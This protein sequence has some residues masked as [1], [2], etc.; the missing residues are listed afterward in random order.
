MFGAPAR[1]NHYLSAG[2]VVW[3]PRSGI[4]VTR[5]TVRMVT[6]RA[7][8]R[9]GSFWVRGPADHPRARPVH[10]TFED[11]VNEGSDILHAKGRRLALALAALS[12]AATTMAMGIVVAAL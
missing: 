4:L 10:D 5:S 2:F 7:V 8:A 3:R 6:S 11:F 1:C 12:L 9:P